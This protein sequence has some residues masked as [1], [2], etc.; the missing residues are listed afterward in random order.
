MT[1][2]KSPADIG[3]IDFPR[4]AGATPAELSQR[5]SDDQVK[6]LVGRDDGHGHHVP[7]AFDKSHNYFD[8]RAGTVDAT[9]PIP[10][11]AFP[12]GLDRWHRVL[13]DPTPAKQSQAEATA[14]QVIEYLWWWEDDGRGGAAAAQVAAHLVDTL[15]PAQRAVARRARL[16]TG[17]GPEVP[18]CY[19]QQDEY[20][21]WHADHDAQGRLVR[22]SFTAEPP[23]YWTFLA[24]ADPDL[25]LT[26]Y[27]ELVGPQVQRDDVF[28][29]ADL[30]IYGKGADGHGK[31]LTLE[32]AGGYNRFNKW[33]STHG[34]VH[35]T[36]WANTLGAEI[37][38]AAKA[39]NVWRSDVDGPDPALDDDPA[40]TRIACAGYGGINRSSDPS[41]GEQVGIQVTAG[42]LVS[43]TNPIGLYIGRVDLAS[44]E[45]QTPQGRVPVAEADV[46][47][48]T[49][50]QVDPA[51]PRKLHFK[52]EAPHGA[53]WT[54]GDCFL[55][56]RPLE[57]GGQVARKVTMALYA[58]VRNGGADQTPHPCRP[59]LVCR[60]PDSP[61]FFGTFRDGDCA[62]LTAAD[63]AEDVPL[64][65]AGH[66]HAGALTEFAAKVA[67]DL[68]F[69]LGLDDDA[70]E[71][72]VGDAVAVV[73]PVAP[74]RAKPG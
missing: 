7:G 19:R 51:R 16:G 53:D 70:G 25:V 22:L 44:L 64:E 62:A 66:P 31:W 12:R 3:S 45:R 40:L 8:M 57:R 56:N 35:L 11:N 14:D 24:E 73:P 41:I 17:T 58:D 36:H 50:G 63:W 74:S 46:L 59:G 67:I 49:R 2:L 72:P 29:P 13:S 48:V 68:G 37:D 38:L 43:L 18:M 71:A 39:S 23:E 5:W 33:N 15:T 52:L 20:C 69:A 1:L 26:L 54:L 34:C 27:R 10:W 47:T 42:N 32:K 4:A 60:H 61:G 55:E 6:D 30:V 21:E 65:P 28:Y 9:A